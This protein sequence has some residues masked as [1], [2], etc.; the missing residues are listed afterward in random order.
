MQ[1]NGGRGKK[2]EKGNPTIK[3]PRKILVYLRLAYQT[4]LSR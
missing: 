4:N 1:G 2:M 3:D